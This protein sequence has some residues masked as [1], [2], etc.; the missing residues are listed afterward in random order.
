MSDGLSFCEQVGA[1]EEENRQLVRNISCLFKTA[2]TEMYRKDREIR[3]LRE[4]LNQLRQSH[5]AP[6]ANTV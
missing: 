2:Q 5:T 1:L 6:L 3:Q 4:Q